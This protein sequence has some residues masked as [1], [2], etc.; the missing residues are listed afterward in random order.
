MSYNFSKEEIVKALETA[1]SIT[2]AARLMGIS[3]N[4][5]TRLAKKYNCCI[6]NQAGK[7]IP[8]KNPRAVTRE[9]LD[10]VFQNKHYITA[11][12][13]KG[14]LF[15]FELKERKCEC[16]GLSEWMDKDIPL[17][18]HHKNGNHHDNT[19]DN[20]QI[21]CPNCHGQTEHYRGANKVSHKDKKAE[22]I[23]L[24]EEE[25]NILYPR[26]EEVKKQEKQEKQIHKNYSKCLACGKDFETSN[27]RTKFC[28]VTCMTKYNSRHIPSKEDFIEVIKKCSSV[29]Q[30]ARYYNMSDNGIKRWIKKYDIDIAKYG[31]RKLKVKNNKGIFS[32]TN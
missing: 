16:C 11:Y 3:Y 20:L 8:R 10:L 7:G 19:W 6:T 26:K 14:Y 9:V 17:E 25:K 5:F 21:L 31:Y 30:L 13:L 27:K 28:S 23:E 18:L 29:M 1:K 24:T 22:I 32:N 12:K 2:G 4:A 15:K